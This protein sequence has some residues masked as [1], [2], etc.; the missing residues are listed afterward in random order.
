MDSSN[1]IVIPSV[2]QDPHRYGAVEGELLHELV[3]A[4]QMR[5]IQFSLASSLHLSFVFQISRQA[6]AMAK[7]SMKNTDSPHP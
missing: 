2:G 5:S 1:V 7:V 6:I 4:G 3:V